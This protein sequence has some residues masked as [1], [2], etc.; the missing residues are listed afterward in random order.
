[1][2]SVD[3][4]TFNRT[5]NNHQLKLDVTGLTYGSHNIAVFYSGDENYLSGFKLETL[6]V[7]RIQTEITAIDIDEVCYGENAII[8]VRVPESVEGDIIIKLNDSLKTTVTQRIH[9]GKAIFKVSD[10]AAG[11]Y[12]VNV[13]YPGNERYD[14]IDTQFETFEVKKADPELTFVSFEGVVYSNATIMVSISEEINDEFVNI[15][16]GD[17]KYPN[18]PIYYGMVELTTDALDEITS[19]NIVVEYGGNDNFKSSKIEDYKT[20]NKISTYGLTIKAN[21]IAINDDEI[22]TVEVPD[23]VDDVV[24]WVDGKSYRNTSFTDN[25]AI[26]KITNLKEGVYTVTATVNDTEFDH[27]NFTEIFTVSKVSPSIS[28]HIINET[29]IR[30]GDNVKITVTVPSDASE[31]VSITVDGRQFSQKPVNGNATFF[32]EDITS[33]NKAVPAIYGGDDK[34]MMNFSTAH[35]TVYKLPSFVNVLT[36]VISISDS[37]EI[38]FTLPDDASG[39]ITVLVNNKTYTVAVS[40]GKGNLVISKLHKDYYSVIATYNGDGKYLPSQNSTE[41]F[42]VI[43][44]SDQMEIIDEMNNTLSVYLNENANGNVTVEIDGK[45]YN[46]TVINGTAKVLLTNAQKG[47]CHAHVTYSD[48][49]TNETLESV[50]DVHIPKYNTALN[51][52]M[53]VMKIGDTGYINVTVPES[54]TGNITIEIEGKSYAE[55]IENGIAKFELT[56]FS[57]GDATLSIKYSGDDNFVEN[58]TSE[59]LTVF[60]KESS[61]AVNVKNINV[62]EIAQINITGPADILGVV[63]VNIAGINYTA[64]LSKGFGTVNVDNLQEGDYVIIATYLENEKYLSCISDES[65]LFVFKN[66]S[67]FVCFI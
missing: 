64:I 12:R 11:S 60:K 21:N 24:I 47:T 35:F 23:H 14:V 42:K 52:Q 32:I 8:T 61:I 58:S 20:P 16:V 65:Y 37:E 10:L 31:N 43:I 50:I 57:A 66:S 30:A 17:V 6:H 63:T 54:A 19:Y 22:I 55:T 3:N 25:K 2:V 56:L 41:M 40:E 36:Q 1:M 7:K 5:I 26:F 34:Y 27:R 48:N 9:D 44:N 15:T 38:K 59:K 13:I 49:V 33:G 29:P 46:A 18:C 53:S 4:Q 67:P 62:G 39:N 45:L 51:A 28:I